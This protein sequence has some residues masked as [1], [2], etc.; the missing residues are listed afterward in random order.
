MACVPVVLSA[1]ALG[2]SINTFSPYSFYGI[3]DLE[4]PV[5]AASRGM[6]GVGIGFRSDKAMNLQN[7][8]SY[9]AIGRQD[10]SLPRRNRR[11]RPRSCV[12][13]RPATAIFPSM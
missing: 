13:R 8:A 4:N 1:Q 7:P 11:A 12:R 2:S 5:T 9:S 3:G 6:G 10:G